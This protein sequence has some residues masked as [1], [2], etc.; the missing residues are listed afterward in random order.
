MY[1][2]TIIRRIQAIP[3]FSVLML[4]L[5][6][7]DTRLINGKVHTKTTLQMRLL[8]CHGHVRAILEEENHRRHVSS[9]SENMHSICCEFNTWGNGAREEQIRVTIVTFKPVLSQI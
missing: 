4:T 9:F 3:S 8:Q 5:K 1:N 7:W 2:H 6:S